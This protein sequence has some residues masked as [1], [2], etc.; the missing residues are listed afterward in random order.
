MFSKAVMLLPSAN[1][2][3]RSS[4]AKEEMELALRRWLMFILSSLVRGVEKRLVARELRVGALDLVTEVNV[5][6]RLG[7]VWVTRVG[8]FSSE[9]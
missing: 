7:G 1:K 6:R 4:Y 2:P 5:S 9:T 8:R 3:I